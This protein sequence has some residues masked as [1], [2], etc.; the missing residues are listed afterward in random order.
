[1]Q[2]LSYISFLDL[3]QWLVLSM[4]GVFIVLLFRVVLGMFVLDPAEDAINQYI[5]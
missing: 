3:N 5:A 2:L 1:M 4:F